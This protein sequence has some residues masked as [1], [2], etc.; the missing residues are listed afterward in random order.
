[1]VVGGAREFK[2]AGMQGPASD[3]MSMAETRA[4]ERSVSRRGLLLRA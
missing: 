1:M 3:P 4:T 2:R